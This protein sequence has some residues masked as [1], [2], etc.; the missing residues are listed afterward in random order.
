MAGVLLELELLSLLG[1]DDKARITARY[2]GFD[3][4]GGTTL[5][6]TGSEYGITAER[7]RQ[8]VG[9]VVQRVAGVNPPAPVLDAVLAAIQVRVP[10]W[11]D[12]IEPDLQAAGHCG[13]PFRIEGILRAAELL[14]RTPGFSL[15]ETQKARL[16][17]ALTPQ[18]LDAIVR[19]ARRAV[20]RRGVTTIQAVSADLLEIAP[21]ASDGRLIAHVLA[22]VGDLRWLD[23]AS[24]WFWLPTV[25]RNPLVRRIRKVLSVANPARF[26]DLCAGIARE[27]QQQSYAPPA[28]VL[29][30]LCRQIPGLRVEGEQV[31]ADPRI[32]PREVLGEL[33][34]AIVDVLG[35]HGGSLRRTELAAI[36]LGKGLNRS[37]FYSALSHSPVIATWPGGLLAVIGKGLAQEPAQSLGTKRRSKYLHPKARAHTIRLLKP[38]QGPANGGVPRRSSPINPMLY[39]P[40]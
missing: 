19:V 38:L 2:C 1:G 21:E 5:Q 16:V 26:A 9:Q 11:A 20:E 39:P 24:E 22:G 8:I 12:D 10:G 33:E 35:E 36:C 15:V 18:A 31:T 3:G 14:G 7:V 4:M 27:Y 30:E 17:H 40:S 34:Q 37:S 6:V 32:D 13:I 23:R 29:R 25:P 28:A